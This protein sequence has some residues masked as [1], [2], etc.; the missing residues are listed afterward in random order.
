MEAKE[1][2]SPQ[3]KPGISPTK[4]LVIRTLLNIGCRPNID[5]NYPNWINF[6]SPSGDSF[7]IEV[8]ESAYVN[9]CYSKLYDYPD[10]K[11]ISA[12]RETIDQVNHDATGCT[13]VSFFCFLDFYSSVD[14]TSLFRF[15][16]EIPDP[17]KYLSDKLNEMT[18]AI[19]HFNNEMNKKKTTE[20]DLFQI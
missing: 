7:R 1:T 20:E 9:L 3:Q 15:L 10:L 16:P 14:F 17:E 5:K 2:Q 6:L 12:I 11:T 8:D 18:Q 19:N 13:T 4:D